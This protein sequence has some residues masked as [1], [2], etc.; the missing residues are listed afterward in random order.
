MVTIYTDGAFSSNRNQGGWAFIVI[1]D[2]E[3][4]TSDW[5]GVKNTTNNRMEMQS[6]LEALYWLKEEKIK[7]ATIVSDSMYVIGTMRDNWKRN[8]NLDLWYKLDEAVEGLKITWVHVK[9]HSGNKYNERCDVLAVQGSKMRI[10]EEVEINET[11]EV[12]K[13]TTL[14][15][16]LEDMKAAFLAGCYSTTG[17]FD[18]F[19]ELYTEEKKFN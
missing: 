16:T 3:I 6:V 13:K 19:I 10:P 1:E 4:I 9:G 14:S 17:L 5:D 2:N 12:V 8:A 11:K 18:E 7:E 15:F